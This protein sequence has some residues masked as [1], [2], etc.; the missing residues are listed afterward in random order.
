M[1]GNYSGDRIRD[2]EELVSL[3]KEIEACPYYGTRRAVRA[4]HIVCMYVRTQFISIYSLVSHAQIVT[5][6][7]A[8]IIYAIL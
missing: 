8:S 2:I 4:A 7:T 5:T 3:G 1:L 6:S